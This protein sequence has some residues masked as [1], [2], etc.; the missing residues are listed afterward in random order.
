MPTAWNSIFGKLSI[1]SGRD[2]VSPSYPSD[3]LP[4]PNTP[5]QSS[6]VSQQNQNIAP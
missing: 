6:T 5:R 3:P 1:L 2:R 4:K